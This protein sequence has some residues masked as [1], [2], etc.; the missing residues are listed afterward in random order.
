MLVMRPAAVQWSAP[1]SF[2]LYFEAQYQISPL[3]I[4]IIIII[5]IIY[6]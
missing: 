2:L 6:Y 1:L 4:I 3:F 5:I